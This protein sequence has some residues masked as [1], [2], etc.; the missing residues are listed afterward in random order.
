LREEEYGLSFLVGFLT[1]TGAWKA[2][3]ETLESHATDS[4]RS[5]LTYVNMAQKKQEYR[6][7]THTCWRI[8]TSRMDSKNVSNMKLYL[9]ALPPHLKTQIPNSRIIN[10]VID[11]YNTLPNLLIS[12]KPSRIDLGAAPRGP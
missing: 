5:C 8:V 10:V 3:I 4:K 1:N 12:Y 9:G 2:T 6:C 7:R 11:V